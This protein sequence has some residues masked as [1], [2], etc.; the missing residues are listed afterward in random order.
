[1]EAGLWQRMGY[2]RRAETLALD[3]FRAGSLQAEPLLKTMYAARTGADTGFGDYLVARLRERNTSSLPALRPTPAFSTT[4]LAGAAIDTAAL[5]GRITVL[6]FWFIGCPPCKAERPKLNAIVDEFG[7]KVRFV[8]FAL[9]P[10]AALQKYQAETPFKYEIVPNSETI[11]RAFGVDS[12]PRH[13]VIDRGGKIV[14]LSGSDDDRIER[15]R[16]MIVRV[17]ASEVK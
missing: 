12:Y 11:A 15:L 16:A 9:D 13:M 2:T 6:D 4:T 3:A 17:L 7:D 1:M 10:A 5:T 8:G 14:W